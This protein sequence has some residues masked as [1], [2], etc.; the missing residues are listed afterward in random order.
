MQIFIFVEIIISMKHIFSTLILCI[1]FFNI[2]NSQT[3]SGTITDA[4]NNE[5]LIGANIILDNGSGTS[6]NI[7]GNYQIKI[8]EGKQQITFKYIG[9]DD[10]V[11]NINA[12]KNK[13]ITLNI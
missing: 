8:K 7:N 2:S 5:A 3:I 9:Y 10:I 11:E 12:Q 6:T 13:N 4:S 1:I